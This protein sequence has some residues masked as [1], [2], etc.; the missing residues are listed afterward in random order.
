MENYIKRVAAQV[1]VLRDDVQSKIAKV[2][3]IHCNVFSWMLE[4]AAAVLFRYAVDPA[5]G[6]TSYEV[7]TGRR[8]TRPIASFGEKILYMPIKTKIRNSSKAEA[9]MKEGFW[10]GSSD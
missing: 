2:I 9:R 4:W 8:T 7:L 10:L 1:R 3:P 5:S 6:K